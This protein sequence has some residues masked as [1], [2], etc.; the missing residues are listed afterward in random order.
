MVSQEIKENWTF[1]KKGDENWLPACVP[2]CVHTDL[3]T[4]KLIPDPFSGDYEE[5][6]AWIEKEEWE[7]H[8]VFN[9]SSYI[10]DHDKLEIWFY[11]IDTYAEISLNGHSIIRSNN[12]YHPW[13]SDVKNLLHEGENTISIVFTPAV[14]RAQEKHA[15]RISENPEA[16]A[17]EEVRLNSYSR[18]SAYQYGLREIPRFVTCG[19]WKNIE[20][21]AFNKLKI[22]DYY[23]FQKDL[24]TS[25]ASLIC[26]LEL[27]VYSAGEYI[28]A[29]YVDK[30]LLS[31]GKLRLTSGVNK[32]SLPFI[33]YNPKLWYPRGYGNPDLYKITI[34]IKG[35][36]GIIDTR[37]TTTGIRKVELIQDKTRTNECF[38]FRVNGLDVY[39][40]GAN[41]LPLDYFL[42]RIKKDDYKLLVDNAV[43]VNINMLRVWGGGI[44]EHDCLYNLCNREGIMIWQDFM[45][46]D[47]SYPLDNEFLASV[48]EE[49][50]YNIKRLR[51]H[52]SLF[53]WCGNSRVPDYPQ[54]EANSSGSVENPIDSSESFNR[55]FHK[56]LPETLKDL[57]TSQPY[58]P[59]STV[60]IMNDKKEIKAK[61]N[62]KK[63]SAIFNPETA[64]SGSNENTLISQLRIAQKIKEEIE[65]QRREKPL[66]MTSFL[67]QLNCFIP[68]LSD[69]AIDYKG[70]WNPVMYELKHL[71][72]DVIISQLI[73][74][75]QLQVYVS[76]DLPKPIKTRILLRLLNFEG[77]VFF[78]KEIDYQTKTNAA[79]MVFSIPLEKLNVSNLKNQVVLV[80]DIF[81]ADKRLDRNLHFFVG[82]DDLLLKS[83]I[84]EIEFNISG[85]KTIIALKSPVLMK[86]VYLESSGSSGFFSDN[87]FDLLPGETKAVIFQSDGNSSEQSN[88][89]IKSL[90]VKTF[91]EGN[92]AEA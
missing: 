75:N 27:E 73:K 61:P 19:I 15:K 3:L 31:T 17:V 38:H 45:F 23:V 67:H 10:L 68:S 83:A 51:N 85:N 81:Q 88:F 69:S 62:P 77:D 26:E 59:S 21:L 65:K 92:Q 84:P 2:G 52:P 79:E 87:F 29:L 54:S 74:F 57:E 39:V 6:L 7:Y 4:N 64:N 56:L 20:L 78:T 55:I 71:Y 63:N 66:C 40:K 49:A 9:A 24:T 12:M 89:T 50:E 8:C 1:R 44:Y 30:E 70:K 33:I 42:P 41:I 43:S 25:F 14:I 22:R 36:N 32:Y 82:T 18:K 60:G 53:I 91:G 80:A 72:G 5:E 47:K 28:F 48:R 46:T 11:G 90:G 37:Q 13:S 86:N 35:E 58:V 34:D 16:N 76:A